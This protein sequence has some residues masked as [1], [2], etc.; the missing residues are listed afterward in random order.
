[1]RYIARIVF[2][3]APSCVNVLFLFSGGQKGR[4]G[5]GGGGSWEIVSGRPL[6]SES[7]M[8]AE[9][10]KMLINR[11]WQFLEKGYRFRDRS[12][13]NLDLATGDIGERVRA[14]NMRASGTGQVRFPGRGNTRRDT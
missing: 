7:I 2:A 9:C 10:I 5:G 6:Y 13:G 14:E 12:W 3:R 8:L 4:G 1:M 11:A